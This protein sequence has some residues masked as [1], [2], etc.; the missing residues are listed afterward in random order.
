MIVTK[1]CFRTVVHERNGTTMRVCTG[2]E[3]PCWHQDDITFSSDTPE[4]VTKVCCRKDVSK[5]LGIWL[6]KDWTI[7]AI[8][9]VGLC[10]TFYHAICYCLELGQFRWSW[11]L[12][13]SGLCATGF[14]LYLRSAINP[15]VHDQAGHWVNLRTGSTNLC[16]GVILRKKA[17]WP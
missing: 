11:Y 10:Y 6:A 7:A 5:G 8:F 14:V 9:M 4:G 15:I 3:N 12:F 13:W 16:G 1:N 17:R 2:Q